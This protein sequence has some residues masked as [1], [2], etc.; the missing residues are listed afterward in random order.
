MTEGWANS[1]DSGKRGTRPSGR[2]G[3]KGKKNGR[4]G[5]RGGKRGT[6]P[7]LEQPVANP[8]SNVRCQICGHPVEP[9]RLHFHMVRFHGA[10]LRPGRP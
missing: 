2:K 8:A 7:L 9:K 6:E 5:R 4:K 10:S 1:S 3:P